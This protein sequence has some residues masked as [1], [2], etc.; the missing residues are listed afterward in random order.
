MTVKMCIMLDCTQLSPLCLRISWCGMSYFSLS[1]SAVSLTIIHTRGQCTHSNICCIIFICNIFNPV[2]VWHLLYLSHFRC[3]YSERSN[4]K[5]IGITIETR[6]D[7][8]LKKHLRYVIQETT[9]DSVSNA[10]ALDLCLP[11]FDFDSESEHCRK[12][13]LWEVFDERT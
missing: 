9:L 8:C 5:C 7:Y 11:L 2:C 13:S 4:T 10:G 12:K 1:V 6:P 3:R